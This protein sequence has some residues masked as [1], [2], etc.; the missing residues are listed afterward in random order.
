MR[1]ESRMR[2]FGLSVEDAEKSVKLM[3][4]GIIIAIDSKMKQK[5]GVIDGN[6]KIVDIFPRLRRK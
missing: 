4:S 5:W 1:A 3:E 6:L 2:E